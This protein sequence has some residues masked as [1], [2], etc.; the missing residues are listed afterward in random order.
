MHA[1]YKGVLLGAVVAVVVMM[2]G[3]A[4]A[5]SGIGAVFNLGKAN[6]AN[7]T[8]Y[9]SGAAKG[10]LLQVT[11]K[12]SGAAL[13]LKV[14]AGKAPLTVNSTT[15][16]K[17]LNADLVDG[18]HASELRKVYTARRDFTLDSTYREMLTLPGLVR[19]SALNNSSLNVMFETTSQE[20]VN[21]ATPGHDPY[22]LR[23]IDLGLVTG[24]KLDAT[25]HYQYEARWRIWS[26]KRSAIVEVTAFRVPVPGSVDFTVFVEATV[27]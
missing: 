20:T 12:G 19:I 4:L 13:G 21:L 8:S 15:R 26:S 5:G 25:N 17:R 10:K 9:L 11:N 1:F 14:R 22:T 2:A 18:L 3:T 6:T 27:Q 16:V 23:P 7:R 24:D